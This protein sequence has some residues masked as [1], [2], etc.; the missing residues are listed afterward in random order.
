M[1]DVRSGAPLLDSVQDVLDDLDDPFCVL[2]RQRPDQ[3][4]VDDAENGGVGSNAQRQ[5]DD[6][7]GGKRGA[8][9]ELP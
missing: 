9:P 2:V 4:R 3:N 1:F 6:G 8:P 7:D 5:R